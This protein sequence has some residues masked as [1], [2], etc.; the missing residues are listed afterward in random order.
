MAL[1]VAVL[2]ALPSAAGSLPADTDTVDPAALLERVRSSDDISYTAYGE[3]RG[4]LVLPDVDALGDLPDLIS[5]TTRLRAFWRDGGDFRVDA[6]T[7][8]GELDVITADQGTWTWTWASADRLATLVRG[9]LD[10]RLPRG[11]DL[12]APALGARLARSAG[13]SASALPPRRVAGRDAVGLRLVP[14]SPSTTTI[15]MVDLWADP[16]TGLPLRVE[17]HSTAEDGADDAIALTSVLLDLELAPPAAGSTSFRPP[18]GARVEVVEAPDVAAASDRFAPFELPD[19]L[20]GLPRRARVDDVGQGVGTYG[21]GLTALTVVPL[22]GRTSGRLLEQ[23]PRSGRDEA[24][25]ATDLLQG[26]VARRGER[27][28]LLVGTVPQSLLRR[29]LAE[30]AASPPPLRAQVDL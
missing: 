30:L 25:V 27:A 21:D 15:A 12:L 5:G 7:L 29:A 11:A 19:E 16:G 20:A 8:V 28:Y 6:L 2:A 14:D 17:L 22:D 26:L 24:E 10:V 3:A 23:L 18:P 13:L 9:D 4:D 1:V